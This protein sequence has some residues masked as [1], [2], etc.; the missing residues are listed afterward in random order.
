M[1]TQH[2]PDT[3]TAEPAPGIVQA[4]VIILDWLEHEAEEE[5]A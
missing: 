5:A 4:W 2:A 3:A 1:T